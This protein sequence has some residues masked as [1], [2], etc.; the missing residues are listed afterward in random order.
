[1]LKENQRI[2]NVTMVVLD[3][4]ICL[5]SMVLAFVIRFNVLDGG[6]DRIG[7]V[8]YLRLMVLVIPFYF[9]LYQYFGLHDSF[10]S[11]AL[12]SEIGKIVQANMVGSIF[13]FVL[14]FFLKEVNVSR[15]VVVLFAGMNTLFG[16][17]ERVAIRKILR[18]LR[19]KGYN[20]KQLLIVGWNQA[21][22][23]FYDKIMLNRSLGYDVCGYLSGQPENVGKRNLPYRGTFQELSNLLEN[24]EIDEVVISLDYDEFPELEEIID[25]CER[26]GVKSSLLPFYT[27]FLP[28]R[29]YID[30]VEGMPLINLRRVPLDNLVNGFLKRSFDI[31]ASLL[32]LVFLSPVFLGVAIGVKCSSPGPV[33]Y[34]QTR[35][36]RRKREFTMY[37]FRSMEVQ[38]E[39]EEKKAWTVKNDPRV[40]PIG[41]FM[42][43]TSIDELPQLFNILKGNMSLVGPRPERP[44]FVEKF[45]EE[46]PRYMVKHQVRPGLTG[47]AQVNG[48]R[49]DTSIRKRIEY[50]LYYIENW[51]IG[52]DIKII[53]LTFF[54]GF[55]NKNAY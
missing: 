18:R 19:E 11:K 35:I 17:I 5:I 8:Y 2:F 31:V 54:K 30:V 36:G 22:G 28:T 3:A 33:I 20:L 21:S 43:H 47:W 29:P 10:R 41:K 37:K 16:S 26:E 14:V 25:T 6:H 38:P 32:G 42:R 51:S 45:R 44:F 49:G 15:M 52:L 12:V 23:E 9:L 4:C 24:K 48:Y 34:R 27:K 39:S 55:I 13:I 40:T 7:I 50:D 46:I 53:F 1:M